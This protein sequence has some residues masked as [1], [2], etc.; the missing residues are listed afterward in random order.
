VELVS[1]DRDLDARLMA[2][3][4][5][6]YST[7]PFSQ[8]VS[9]VR[10]LSPEQTESLLAR[11][12]DSRGPRDALPAAFEG[13][14]PF[15]FEI[16]VDFGAYRDIGRHRKGYQQ[17]QILTVDHGFLVPP[18]LAEAGLD[19]EFCEVLEQ[20]AEL[21][22][23]VARVHPLAAGYVTP[24]AFLQRVRLIFDPRQIAY[25]IEL[26]SGPEGHFAYRDIAIGMFRA[27]EKVSPMFASLIR[28]KVGSAFLGRMESEQGADARRRAR[29]IKAGDLPAE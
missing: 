10:A 4:V 25:F 19:R 9:K 11:A 13:A 27:V 3:L 12:T 14:E 8:L 15:E 29:M 22:R 2:S 17:Q 24:F 28:A 20:S 18:L 21:Q 26:R 1:W 23:E 16:L 6:D 5:Y 7:L